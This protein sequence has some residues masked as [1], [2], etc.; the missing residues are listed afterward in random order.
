[1][2]QK[3]VEIRNR[4]VHKEYQP[5]KQE[6]LDCI[7]SVHDHR[8]EILRFVSDECSQARC[9][10]GGGTRLLRPGR[11]DTQVTSQGSENFVSRTPDPLRTEIL[12]DRKLEIF[13]RG[14]KEQRHLSFGELRVAPTVTPKPGYRPTF[15]NPG[16]QRK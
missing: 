13:C 11:P 10:L 7:R 16:T 15:V 5:S 12:F 4:F 3:M 14:T 1:M 6:A 8:I 2:P 9:C